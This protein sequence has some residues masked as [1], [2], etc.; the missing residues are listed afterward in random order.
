MY[1]FVRIK[2]RD[3]IS[4][5]NP[6]EVAFSESASNAGDFEGVQSD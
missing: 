4:I 3:N 6:L 2:K 5:T 1:T